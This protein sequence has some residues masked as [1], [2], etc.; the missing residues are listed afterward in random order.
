MNLKR[1]YFSLSGSVFAGRPG[2]R[3]Y[4]SPSF[5]SSRKSGEAEGTFSRELAVQPFSGKE[6]L[7]ESESE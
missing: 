6:L 1:S 2:K 7:G 4:Y 5:A 3:F